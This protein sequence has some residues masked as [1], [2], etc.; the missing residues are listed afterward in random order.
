MAGRKMARRLSEVARDNGKLPG[1]RELADWA[2]RAEGDGADLADL[3][4][5]IVGLA[6]ASGMQALPVPTDADGNAV[7][8][9]DVIYAMVCRHAGER[10]GG[11]PFVV[12][13]LTFD[14]DAWTA[15]NLVGV[16]AD[17]GDCRLMRFAGGGAR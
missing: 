8:V 7:R 16:H 12:T 17:L 13:S 9:G 6:G 10:H 3:E 2:L 11:I 15:S 5:I 1:V 14:G 4:E